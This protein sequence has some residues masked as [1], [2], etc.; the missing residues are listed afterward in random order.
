MKFPVYLLVLLFSVIAAVLSWILGEFILIMQPDNPVLSAGMYF[1]ASAFIMTLFLHL[2]VY[3]FSGIKYSMSDLGLYPKTL[4]LFVFGSIP[5]FFLCGCLLEYLYTAKIKMSFEKADNIV[6]LVDNSLSMK[7][8]DPSFE[9]YEAIKR[10]CALLDNDQTL[11]V[12]WYNDLY[13]AIFENMRITP[14]SSEQMD[15]LLEPHKIYDGSTDVMNVMDAIFDKLNS[16]LTGKTDLIVI[17]DGEFDY[18]NKGVIKKYAK[19]GY[20]VH[21]IGVM[22]NRPYSLKQLSYPT[23]GVY[24]GINDIGLLSDAMTRVYNQEITHLFIDY[25]AI[26]GAFYLFLR[27]LFLVISGMLFRLFQMFIIEHKRKIILI[28]GLPLVLIASV[29]IDAL[30][31]NLYGTAYLARGIMLLFFMVLIIPSENVMSDAHKNIS[32]E[33][34]RYF[35]RGGY[36]A[37]ENR[38]IR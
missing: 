24:L 10:L 29:L 23:G 17:S 2:C 6:V 19:N 26:P 21:T 16:S 4:F 27:V 31:Q 5:V 28:Q 8:T 22:I 1:A 12:Y 36:R 11:G 34:A 18:L 15:K 7:D 3:K 32:P 33:R 13:D 20:K 25:R 35:R 14:D 38:E 9:R 37:G 30:I